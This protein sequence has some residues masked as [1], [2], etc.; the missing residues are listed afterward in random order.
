[1]RLVRCAFRFGI[2]LSLIACYTVDVAGGNNPNKCPS[3]AVI[4]AGQG[5]SDFKQRIPRQTAVAPGDSILDVQ[6][7]YK[8][9]VT[10]ADRDRIT[11]YGGTGIQ[12]GRTDAMVTARFAAVDLTRFVADD[13]GRL[14][15]AIIYIPACVAE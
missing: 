7:S 2:V 3:S 11:Q 5:I 8:S 15:D 6:L 9:T 14:S 4:N 13:P 10:T 12:A 1:M